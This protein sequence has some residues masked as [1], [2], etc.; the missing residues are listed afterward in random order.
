KGPGLSVG[1]PDPTTEAAY[2]HRG[3]RRPSQSGGPAPKLIEI[4]NSRSRSIR[5]LRSPIGDP[6]AI[7]EVSGGLCGCQQPWWWG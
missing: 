2:T 7:L 3:C 1:N 5:G 4:S 6:D